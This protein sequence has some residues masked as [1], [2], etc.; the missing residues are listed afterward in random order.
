MPWTIESAL[1]DEAV[2]KTETT[3]QGYSFWL[4]GIP[5]EIQIVLSVNPARG[6]FNFH[7]SHFIHTPKQIGPYYPSRPWGDDQ[8]YALHLA[9]TAITQYYKEAINAGLAPSAKWLV[10]NEHGI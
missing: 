9:V 4:K 5:V 1:D 2:E 7:L 8:A 6:G 10:P 3:G